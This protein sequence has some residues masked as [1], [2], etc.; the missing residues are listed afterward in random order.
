MGFGLEDELY[1]NKVNLIYDVNVLVDLK[2]EEI[3]YT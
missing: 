2:R 1:V 3:K